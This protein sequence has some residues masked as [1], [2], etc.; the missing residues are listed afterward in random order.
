MQQLERLLRFDQTVLERNAHGL[1][2]GLPE[3]SPQQGAAQ[4]GEQI[5]D[6]GHRRPR[7]S[8]AAQVLH[9]STIIGS[10]RLRRSTSRWYSPSQRSSWVKPALFLRK[11]GG[12]VGLLILPPTDRSRV[13]RGRYTV[14]QN[15]S[16]SN[17]FDAMS[18]RVYP[19]RWSSSLASG[20]QFA[21]PRAL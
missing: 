17:W 15:G 1:D 14:K 9:D 19:S 7:V 10:A 20:D 21:K 2:V 4:F 18:Q 8:S 13:R 3:P 11:I 5:I 16:R 6:A 12:R